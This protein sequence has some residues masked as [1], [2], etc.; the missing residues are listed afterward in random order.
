MSAKLDKTHCTGLGS[1][2]KDLEALLLEYTTAY[3]MGHKFSREIDFVSI[4]CP[5][6]SNL[7]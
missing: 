4:F 1:L 7:K 6:K 2:T 5:Q 3:G